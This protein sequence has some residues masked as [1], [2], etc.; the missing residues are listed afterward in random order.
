MDAEVGRVLEVVDRLGLAENTLVVF[1]SD[2][3]FN[4]GHHGIWGKGN[5]TYPQNMYDTSVLVPAIFRQPGRIPAGAVVDDLVSA[6]DV[7]PTLLEWL[8][9]AHPEPAGLSGSSFAS[10]LRGTP[11]S[12]RDHVVVFDEY[13]PVRMVRTSEWKYVHRYPA[14]PHELYDLRTDPGETTNLHGRAEHAAVQDGM[15]ARLESWFA[16]HVETAHDGAL[17]PVTGWGQRAPL[18]EPAFA[19]GPPQP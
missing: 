16:E 3:G 18:S 14:G 1:T 9:V 10:V 12:A 15:R 4:T 17:L 7:V 19:S 11:S 13:G 8:G 5:G 6:Y 2:N